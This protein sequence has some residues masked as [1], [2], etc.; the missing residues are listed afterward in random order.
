LGAG[1]RKGL[2]RLG[3]YRGKGN[4]ARRRAPLWSS[5]YLGGTTCACAPPS[6]G[7]RSRPGHNLGGS[8]RLGA[9]DGLPVRQ[10][11][12]LRGPAAAKKINRVYYLGISTSEDYKPVMQRWSSQRQRYRPCPDAPGW[13]AISSCSP[14]ARQ[15]FLRRP[16]AVHLRSFLFVPASMSIVSHGAVS[17]SCSIPRYRSVVLI[18]ECP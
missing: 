2:G 3:D 10:G 6:L 12:I 15:P 1:G 16:S 7:S 4:G 11:G 18:L 5:G 13:P 14:G 9:E 8:F 17:R